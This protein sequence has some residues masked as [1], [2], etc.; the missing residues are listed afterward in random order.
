MVTPA[1]D[2]AAPRAADATFGP[3]RR[4]RRSVDFQRVYEAR[5]TA[6]DSVL[7]VF[8]LPN[9]GPET[10]LGLSVSRKVGNAVQRNR[11]KRLLREA[12]RL[13]RAALPPQCDLVVIP[14]RSEPP[15]LTEAGASLV[16]LAGDVYRRLQRRRPAVRDVPPRPKTP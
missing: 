11:W 2:A 12:F 6:A 10:R 15:T 1:D 3:A 7:L 14:R 13:N 8:G 4:V 9:S 5:V 16:R